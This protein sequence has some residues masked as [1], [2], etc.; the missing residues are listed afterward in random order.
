MP[1][2]DGFMFS[3]W[4]FSPVFHVGLVLSWISCNWF[5]FSTLPNQN[6][7]Y[8]ISSRAFGYLHSLP[9]IIPCLLSKSHP[10][11]GLSESLGVWKESQREEIKRRNHG[12]P[13]SMLEAC[14]MSGNNARSQ[15][16][17]RQ[18]RN[19]RVTWTCG[20]SSELLGWAVVQDRGEGLAGHYS[21]VGNRFFLRVDSKLNTF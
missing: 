13:A 17:G 12:L 20:T 18:E 15:G 8:F 5:I 10:Y 21:L 2:S 3:F 16:I 19:S 9:I 11:L 6:H 4:S 1:S 14:R 7:L